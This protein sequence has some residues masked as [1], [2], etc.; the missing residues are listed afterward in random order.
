MLL[1]GKSINDNLIIA[2][3]ITLAVTYHMVYISYLKSEIADLKVFNVTLDVE[4]IAYA[5]ANKDWVDSAKAQNKVIM[6]LIEVNK[7]ASINADK[8][9]TEA[10]LTKKTTQQAINSLTHQKPTN[11]MLKD[12]QTLQANIRHYSGDSK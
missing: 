3:I 12:C 4:N 8:A 7:L 10:Q 5:K 11:D 9:L 1:L 6:D 2:G